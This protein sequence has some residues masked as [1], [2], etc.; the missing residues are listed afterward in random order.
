MRG[1]VNP[2]VGGTTFSFVQQCQFSG[3][4]FKRKYGKTPEK[5]KFLGLI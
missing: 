2:P 3:R 1:I 5:F 4:F